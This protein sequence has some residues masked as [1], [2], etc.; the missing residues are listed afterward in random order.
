MAS[1]FAP[2]AAAFALLVS[3][4]PAAKAYIVPS[5]PG[6]VQALMDCFGQRTF[7]ANSPDAPEIIASHFS[8]DGAR[9]VFRN[10]RDTDENTHYFVR[11]P[12]ASQNGVC[13]IFEEEIFPAS[14]SEQARIEVTY[15][16]MRSRRYAV[17]K[18]WTSSIPQGWAA[19]RYPARTQA[20]GFLTE[21]AC[22]LGDDARYMPLTNVTD[23]VLMSF[24]S[25]WSRIA[26]SRQSLEAAIGK[27]PAALTG[28][29]H[30][31]TPER[32]QRLRERVIQDVLAGGEI[33]YE[34]RCDTGN[35][36]SVFF[37]DFGLDFIHAPS[38]IVLTKV[39]A[40]FQA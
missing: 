21:S 35:T 3:Q 9:L 31:D 8:G 1:K 11:A 2:L 19:L 20:Y 23:E 30:F 27:L 24:Q 18:G 13:R 33:P 40:L 12:H 26:A 6:T 5:R 25:A 37:N 36:C 22:P 10:C 34:Y 28:I 39:Y 14:P 17:L 4:P 32:K 29:E 16:N 15:G 7:S 38:G